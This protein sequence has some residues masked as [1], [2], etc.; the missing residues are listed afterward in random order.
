MY[1]VSVQSEA[2]VHPYTVR[3]YGQLIPLG[4]GR[5]VVCRFICVFVCF[6]G[7]YPYG[8]P[9]PSHLWSPHSTLHTRPTPAQSAP[10]TDHVTTVKRHNVLYL[11]S[12]PVFTRAKDPH[13]SQDGLE[14]CRMATAAHTTAPESCEAYLS[15]PGPACRHLKP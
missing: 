14:A 15:A 2:C 5:G 7:F 6:Y 3:V 1:T 12:R 4:L 13:R 8:T 9:T 11:T 10:C